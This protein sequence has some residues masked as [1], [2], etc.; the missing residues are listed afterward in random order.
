[1]HQRVFRAAIFALLLVLLAS[2]AAVLVLR[3]LGAILSA[4]LPSDGGD[5]DFGRIFAQ[6]KD[7]SITPHLLLPLILSVPL[8]WLFAKRPLSHRTVWLRV[9][10]WVALLLVC[11]LG[12]F[13]SALMLT[14]V[15]DIRFCDLLAALLPVLGAL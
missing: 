10:V 5:M 15:N 4:L 8:V 11:L 6:T 12:A 3:N 13:L 2:V 14:H 7:A 1:M 9:L